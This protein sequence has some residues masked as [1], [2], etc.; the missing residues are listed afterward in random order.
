MAD[1][2]I[3]PEPIKAMNEAKYSKFHLTLIFIISIGAFV[4]LYVI[5]ELGASTFSIIPY[6]LHTTSAFSFTAAMLFAGSAIGVIFIGPLVD[7]FG[8]R[9]MIIIPLLLMTIFSITSVISTTPYI[10]L[11]LF[12]IFYQ[13]LHIIQKAVCQECP[14]ES[15]VLSLPWINYI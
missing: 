6:L 11:F 9:A 15:P 12:S 4:D 2:E 10:T 7:K 3:L 1:V 8:R 14:G 5:G 13:F